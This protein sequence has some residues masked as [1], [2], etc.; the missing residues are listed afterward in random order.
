MRQYGFHGV[1]RGKRRRIT[2]PD[3]GAERPVDLVERPF[4]AAAPNRLRVG[5]FTYVMTWSGVVNVAF[6]I[7]GFSRRIVGWKADTT[8]KTSLVLDT[9]EMA[10]AG[11]QYTRFAFTRR[12]VDVG[13]DAS[14]ASVGDGYDNALAETTIGLVNTKKIHRGDRGARSQTSRW[15]RSNGSSGSTTGASIPPAADYPGGAGRAI[16]TQSGKTGTAIEIAS[17]EPGPV[18]PGFHTEHRTEPSSV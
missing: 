15:P 6:V 12:L 9:L 4:T 3:R 5:G 11:S 10:L 14:V 7:D 16:S 1:V 18:H 2:I 13:L 8:I 17:N